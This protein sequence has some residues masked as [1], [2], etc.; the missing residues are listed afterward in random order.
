MMKIIGLTGG[1]ATGKS[2]VSRLLRKYGY[3]V[4]DAD[5]VVHDLQ[6]VGSPILAKI[7]DEFGDF[8][9]ASDGS[10][11]RGVLGQI[12]FENA[13]ARS[14]LEAIMHPAVRAEFERRIAKSNVN[15]L[16]LDVPLL[17]EAG[18]TDLTTLNLVISASKKNQ[19]QRLM[20][21]DGYTLSQAQARID[22][23][24]PLSA[25]IARADFVIDNNGDLCELEEN[26]KRFLGEIL[27]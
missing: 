22:S 17:F 12:I 13:D 9:F 14:R 2:S 10:L 19:L 7:A 11:D 6:E 1:I 24:M 26:V 5:A 16:F 27:S 18:F 23:Q 3:E 25:K 8:L 15:V 20:K 4:I 21:R